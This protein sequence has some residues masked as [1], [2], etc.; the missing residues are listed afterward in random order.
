MSC[1]YTA[2]HTVRSSAQRV[3]TVFQQLMMDKCQLSTEDT[4]SAP[5]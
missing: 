4:A 3:G 5:G 1:S 2:P